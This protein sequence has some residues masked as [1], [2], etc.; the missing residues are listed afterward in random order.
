MTLDRRPRGG[1]LILHDRKSPSGI[2][3]RLFGLVLL[4]GGGY[5]VLRNAS[6]LHQ[7][8]SDQGWAGFLCPLACFGSLALAGLLCLLMVDDLRVDLATRTY[9]RRSG[10]WPSH[11]RQQGSLD[12]IDSIQI[13]S[14]MRTVVSRVAGLGKVAVTIASLNWQDPAI[15]PVCLA[16]GRF[17]EVEQVLADANAIGKLTGIPVVHLQGDDRATEAQ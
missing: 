17:Q 14:E 11:R 15:Q 7:L 3:V 16:E 2:L 13:R 6:N 4:A 5:A 8:V 1:T 12:E 9:I 10:L